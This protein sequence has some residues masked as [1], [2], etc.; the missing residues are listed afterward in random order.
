MKDEAQLQA[1]KEA[2]RRAEDA[3]ST[4]RIGMQGGQDFARAQQGLQACRTQRLQVQPACPVPHQALRMRMHLHCLS[5]F[6]TQ[7]AQSFGCPAGL[8]HLA[9][10]CPP[11]RGLEMC[12]LRRSGSEQ[13]RS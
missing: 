4:A 9:S 2:C 5:F 1:C 11:Y 3:F 13:S 6:Q 8:G 12:R 7:P 10:R